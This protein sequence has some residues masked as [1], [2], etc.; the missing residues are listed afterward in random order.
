M[1]K[2]EVQHYTLCD[3]WVNTWHVNDELEYFETFEDAIIEL[4]CFLADTQEDFEAGYL[5]SPYKRS[6]FKIVEVV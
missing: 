1:I 4:D 3:G 2:Y 5:E 6:E